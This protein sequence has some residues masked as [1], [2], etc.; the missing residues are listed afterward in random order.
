MAVE[1][2][3]ALGQYE[4]VSSLGVGGMGEVYRARDTKLGREVAI[5]LLLEEVSEDPERLAR[6]EREA[7]VLASLNHPSIA[8][9]HGFENEGDTS[10][11][12]MELVEGETLADRI[13]RGPVPP[14]EAIAIFLSIAEALEAAH[15]QGVIHRD[16]KPANVK[17]GRPDFGT[18][19]KLLDFGLAKAMSES[20]EGRDPALSQ[21][22][23]MTLAATMRG[24]IMGTAAYMSPE[25]VQGG[26]V[27]ERADIWAFGVCLL[28]SL[29]G[30]PVFGGDTVSSILAAVLRDAPDL[31]ALPPGTP[32]PLRRLLLR[33]LE[34]NPRERL[35]HIADARLE[36]LDALRAEEEGSGVGGSPDGRSNGALLAAALAGAALAATV[37]VL[38]PG[39]SA[40]APAGSGSLKHLAI[41]LPERT[42]LVEGPGSAFALSPAGDALVFGAY[43]DGT[44]QLY[45]HRFDEIE[46][47][48]LEGTAGA[49]GMSFSHDGDWVAYFAE[50]Q[51]WKTAVEGGRP[52]P[53]RRVPGSASGIAWTTDDLIIYGDRGDGGNPLRSVP[54]AGGEVEEVTELQP[55]EVDHRW[56]SLSADGKVL[57][58]T[59]WK[60]SLETAEVV[61]Q[62][63][64]TGQRRVV[65]QGTQAKLAP[66]G[67]LL[68]ARRESLWSVRFD[69]EAM[70][71][72]G[73]E[74]PVSSEISVMGAG[75]AHY[76]VG[77]DG[78][79]V[80]GSILAGLNLQLSRIG[81]DGARAPVP[82]L[83]ERDWFTAVRFSGNGERLAVGRGNPGAPDLWIYD[84]ERGTGNR[85]ETGAYSGVWSPDGRQLA[86]AR[87]FGSDEEDIWIRAPDGSDEARILLG[88]DGRRQIPTSWSPDGTVLLFNQG[89][90][91]RG[92]D[93]GV[94]DLEDGTTTAFLSTPADEEEAMFSSD[95]EWVAY[96]SDESGRSEIYLRPFP[97]PGA[98]YRV[99]TDGG[100]FPIWSRSGDAI[101]Y[102]GPVGVMS[103]SVDRADG[104]RL[105]RPRLLFEVQVHASVGGFV[106]GVFDQCPE[107]DCFFVAVR[108][109]RPA[110]LRLIQGWAA[111]LSSRLDSRQR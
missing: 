63:L 2:G 34:K 62:S 89:T 56:P 51:L 18:P 96:T 110:P 68:F 107:E 41:P 91:D 14:E 11:L 97:G 78:S 39:R 26:E 46:P 9:L 24:E 80:Y 7:R 12:V 87:T 37:V 43:R 17:I 94:L 22:P 20:P 47:R 71:A 58:Y 73:S 61:A 109:D 84:V 85:L 40:E 36:L 81:A 44:D 25:Q 59:G 83:S 55:G 13:R 45:Y 104:I 79:L 1:A 16:L 23:T 42:R 99:S 10:F 76:D 105:G 57:L 31:D 52:V 5:K 53:L 64:S 93:I 111:D 101:F 32:A 70:A 15:A 49:R 21:S 27:D 106:T 50:D 74:I 28:E 90:A 67:V 102:L 77:A 108:D 3:S 86:F 30:R 72:V 38:W 48:L 6:F 66:G 95:G 35:H 54:A 69:Q 4:L 33:C 92:L 88:G 8:T 82:W 98:Q 29:T 65:T 60:G 75:A 103:A 100:R 19:L